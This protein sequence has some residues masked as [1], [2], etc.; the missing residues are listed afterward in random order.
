MFRSCLLVAACAAFLLS[1]G[2]AQ[3][4]LQ[5]AVNLGFTSFLD[6]GPPAGPGFYFQ[7]YFQ[8]WTAD[9]FKDQQGNSTPLLDDL[10]VWVS[11]SQFIYQSNQPVF[12]NG[13]WG[14]DVIV[15][16]VSI[17]ADAGVPPVITD[18]AQ[19][20]GDLLIGPFIQWDPLMGKEGPVFMHRIEL[21][22]LIPT[23][24][25]DAN[26]L[27]NPG[28][29]HY[30]FNPYWAGTLWILPQWTVTCR[31]HYLWNMKNDDPN[32]TLFP[33]VSNTQAGDAVHLNF[34]S[35]VEILPKRLRVG[36]NGYFLQQV[37]DS[38]VNG[39]ETGYRERV[40]GIGPGGV[41]HFSQNDHVFFNVYFETLAESRAEGMR[42]TLRW[43]HHF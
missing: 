32:T 39:I 11:L 25:Y 5:P 10:D 14:I 35:A 40:L 1:P 9:D 22:N 23:G 41:W 27:L 29:N 36:V 24:K 16:L 3:A 21:Q 28:S 7:Q 4:Q 2:K 17:D 20:L 12:L 30:S 6:G 26:D 8:Y 34:A 19:G 43:T 31:V 18:N 42:A 13:K 37:R 15:P 33:G 38:K